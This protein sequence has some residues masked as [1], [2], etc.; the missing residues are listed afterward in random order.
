MPDAVLN[1]PWLS[2]IGMGADGLDSLSGKAQRALEAADVLV[3]SPR[4]FALFPDDGRP[5]IEWSSPLS[6]TLP[7][8]E[9]CRS[10]KVAVIATGDPLCYGVGTWLLTKFP[11][12]DM[13]IIPNISAFA[14]TCARMGWAQ[15]QT[16]LLTLHGRDDVTIRNAI[17]PQ[18]R[19]V[20]LSED[21]TTP[22][23][24]C[25]HLDDLGYQ[26]SII[27][28]FAHLDGRKE[29]VFGYLAKEG[30]TQFNA[31]FEA[32]PDHDLNTIALECVAGPDARILSRAPGNPDNLFSDFRKMT[33]RELRSLAIAR[34]APQPGDVM[35]D[36]GAGSAS[37]AAEFLRLA[38]GGAAYAFDIDA[39]A[40]IHQ[41]ENA[42][43]FG[44]TN[45]HIAPRAEL[46][47]HDK[48]LCCEKPDAIFMGGGISKDAIEA[49]LR[50]L[51]PGG[52]FVCNA[53]TIE[54][55]LDLLSAYSR[56]GGELSRISIARAEPL[57]AVHGFKPAMTITQWVWQKERLA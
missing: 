28:V 3:S 29:K 2:V 49:A 42:S 24:V 41:R 17:A 4:L 6:A 27:N 21:A 22:R 52:R 31:A 44:L 55:E 30:A 32:N 1:T 19:L 10:K 57:G 54:S 48:D 37:V 5:R 40:Q 12:G 26:D 16:Q 20:I 7:A 36:V 35:W 8:I 23:T 9:S 33:K 47:L 50:F 13:I 46:P 51:K 14:L 15:Q 56:Y 18:T 25:A 11:L 39:D 45:L 38:P 34:L 43:R 53:V